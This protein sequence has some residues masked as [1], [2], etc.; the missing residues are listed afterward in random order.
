VKLGDDDYGVFWHPKDFG[1]SY[2][3]TTLSLDELKAIY[4]I[5]SK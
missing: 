1:A 5:L 2:E 3:Y 4:R